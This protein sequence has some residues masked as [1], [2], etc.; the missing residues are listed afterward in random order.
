MN[1]K[2]LYIE[3][4]E[5][6][7]SIVKETLQIKGYSVHHQKEGTK[8]LE[9]ITSFQPDVC[10]LDIMLPYVDGYSLGRTIRQV[11]PKL[12]IIFLTAK[13]QTQDIVDGFSSGGTDYIKKPFSLEELMVRID[14]QILIQHR[15]KSNEKKTTQQE[16]KIGHFRYAPHL[17]KLFGP[18]ETIKLSNRETEILNILCMSPNT[19]ID[20]RELM[21]MIWGDDSYF[22]SRNL[23]V[24]IRRLREY[25]SPGTGVEII[26]L[27]GK[28][29]NFSVSDEGL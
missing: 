26:T 19:P 28:G 14:N 21:K 18:T 15:T 20:R 1:Y 10:V 9:L 16:I 6:L 27:K 29:Y 24:Y 13:S 23:D 8:I 12:P 2:V 17:M 5:H 22:I 7:A 3:D 4:E 25:F 11:Y